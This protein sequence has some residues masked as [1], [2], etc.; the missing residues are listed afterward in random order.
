MIT[1]HPALLA[2]CRQQRIE[3]VTVLDG[4]LLPRVRDEDGV[5]RWTRAAIAINCG[6]VPDEIVEM[7]PLVRRYNC[8]QISPQEW[9]CGCVAVLRITGE[10]ARCGGQPFELRLAAVCGGVGCVVERAENQE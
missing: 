10:D 2:H 8:P 6:G 4:R 1:Y 7:F 5:E 9:D 3:F